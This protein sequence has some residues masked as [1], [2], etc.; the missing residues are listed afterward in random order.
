MPA[1]ARQKNCGKVEHKQFSGRCMAKVSRFSFKPIIFLEIPN[2]PRKK[3]CILLLMM[4]EVKA[5][6]IK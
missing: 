2:S 1:H 4:S 6:N 5:Q 3:I